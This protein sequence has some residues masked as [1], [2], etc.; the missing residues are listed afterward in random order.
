MN[1]L[2]LLLAVSVLAL[3]GCDKVRAPRDPLHAAAIATCKAVIEGRAINKKTV[4]YRTVDV[5]P[6]A[7]GL[8]VAINFSAKNEIG[9]AAFMLANCVT[10]PDGKA[11]TGIT[12][13]TR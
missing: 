11:M 3:A 9:S 2:T 1:K 7:G 10:T 4:S 13:K 6:V 8:N 5:S 12:V